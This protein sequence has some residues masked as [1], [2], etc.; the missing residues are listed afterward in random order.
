[1]NRLLLNVLVMCVVMVTAAVAQAASLDVLVSNGTPGNVL[2][3]D[4]DGTPLGVFASGIVEPR[5]M[6]F[7]LGGR[8]FVPSLESP[9]KGKR[10]EEDGT[11][12]G[13]FITDAALSFGH[14]IS[15]GPDNHLYVASRTTNSVRKYNGATGAFMETFVALA[16]A[17]TDI[18]FIGNTLYVST[19][20]A[21]GDL[22]SYDVTTK[23]FQNN[24]LAGNETIDM[25]VGPDG[26][27][28][29]LLGNSAVYYLPPDLSSFTLFSNGGGSFSSFLS[30]LA[31]LA[32]GDL[33]VGDNTNDTIWRL[34]GVSGSVEGA[35]ATGIA[36]VRAIEVLIPEP[37]TLTLLGLGAVMMLRRRRGS[38]A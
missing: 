20:N 21:G 25:A 38:A 12:L 26:N 18:E 27:I 10:Y 15:I 29:V 1:M 9:F 7:G 6:A 37:A 23:A 36:D 8:V 5:H 24:N 17:P 14:D 35:F 28:Y 3:Y 13:D 34:N 16:S 2:R 31:F 30:S 19:S 22:R 11:P 33:L 4:Q 32:D